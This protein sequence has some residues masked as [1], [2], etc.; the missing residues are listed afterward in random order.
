MAQKTISHSHSKRIATLIAITAAAFMVTACG[1]GDELAKATAERAQAL[2]AASDTASHNKVLA[3]GKLKAEQALAAEQAKVAQLN[4]DL[5]VERDAKERERAAKMRE[6][7]AKTTALVQLEGGK[8]V[9]AAGV[10][11]AHAK[12]VKD[13]QMGIK[14]AKKAS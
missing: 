14:P 9:V 12:G 4:A 2:Q 10:N 13:S 7:A 8:K 6:R 5:V 1:D 3:A 11:A